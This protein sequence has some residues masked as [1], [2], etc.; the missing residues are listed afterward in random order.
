[1]CAVRTNLCAKRTNVPAE[2][3][4]FV[5]GMN[6]NFIIAV[7][8]AT[9]VTLVIIAL[10]L[11]LMY[12]HWRYTELMNG[13]TAFIQRNWKMEKQ[14]SQLEKELKEQEKETGQTNRYKVE[15]SVQQQ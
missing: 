7:A 5:V 10:V 1:M 4:T 13:I 12:Y 11:L 9:V 8:L 14:I 2:Y 6:A 3:T 15:A